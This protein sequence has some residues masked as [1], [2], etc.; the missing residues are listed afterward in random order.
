MRLEGGLLSVGVLGAGLLP[1][2]NKIGGR[3]FWLLACWVEEFINFIYD[4][5]G[6]NF[7]LLVCWVEEYYLYVRD[8]WQGLFGYWR[9]WWRNITFIY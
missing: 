3:Y 6:T 2:L 7:W 5:G 4:T 8:W 9:A 1:F